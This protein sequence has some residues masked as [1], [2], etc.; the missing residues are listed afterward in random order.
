MP[1]EQR[2]GTP[3]AKLIFTTQIYAETSLRSIGENYVKVLEQRG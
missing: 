1:L 3:D 2:L